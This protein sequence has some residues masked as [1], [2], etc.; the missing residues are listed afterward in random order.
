MAGTP[1]TEGEVMK[2]WEYQTLTNKTGL[3]D[4]FLN[5]M[6][7]DGWELISFNFSALSIEKNL[8]IFKRELTPPTE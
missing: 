7:E 4:S 6:G 5:K 8:Y 3:R 2:R 1:K